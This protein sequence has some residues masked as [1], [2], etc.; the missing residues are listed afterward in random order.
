M[1][2]ILKNIDQIALEKQRDVLYVLFHSSYNDIFNNEDLTL[3]FHYETCMA[4]QQL[5]EWLEKH[6]IDFSECFGWSSRSGIMSMPY[7][8][9]IYL[10]VPFDEANP[11]YQLLYNH[12]ENSDGSMKVQG[13]EWFY[14][15]LEKAI[16][17]HNLNLKD[18]LDEDF[19]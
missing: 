16:E 7:L 11:K 15:P 10:D 8:G 1:P 18:D 5:I 9:E 12:L 2:R 3:K 4:R 19:I 6:E 14:Y 17:N 13:I